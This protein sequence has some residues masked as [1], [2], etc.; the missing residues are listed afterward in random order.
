MGL[1]A[2]A[3]ED[4]FVS[5]EE[6]AAKVLA[7]ALKDAKRVIAYSTV[8]HLLLGIMMMYSAAFG[9]ATLE[10]YVALCLALNQRRQ[11]L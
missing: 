2:S 1:A 10:L 4:D 7:A 11:V 9:W 5:V 8:L 3:D 6:D